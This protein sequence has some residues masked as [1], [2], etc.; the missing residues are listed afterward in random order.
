MGSERRCGRLDICSGSHPMQRQ[1][2]APARE[3]PWALPSAGMQPGVISG[4]RGPQSAVETSAHIRARVHGGPWTSLCAKCSRGGL[5]ASIGVRPRSGASICPAM[6]ASMNFDKRAVSLLWRTGHEADIA[7][8]RT[9]SPE[10]LLAEIR[11][12]GRREAEGLAAV[13][14]GRCTMR[15][16]RVSE[17]GRAAA[18]TAPLAGALSTVEGVGSIPEGGGENGN[19]GGPSPAS[20]S[21]SVRCQWCGQVAPRRRRRQKFCSRSCKVAAWQAATGYKR[22]TL[23]PPTQPAAP[24]APP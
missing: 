11:S 4:L 24:P 10:E 2:L 1:R 15:A 13:K 5:R 23:N 6:L 3:G 7:R 21:G 12:A 18:A 14:A 20:F 16:R 9:L 17:E 22:R 19:V 8:A